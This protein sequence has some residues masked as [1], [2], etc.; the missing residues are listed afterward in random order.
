MKESH[1]TRHH[2]SAKLVYRGIASPLSLIFCRSARNSSGVVGAVL[3][4]ASLHTRLLYATPFA[5]PPLQM[6]YTVPSNDLSG[7]K[8]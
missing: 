7:M 2:E 1:W 8:L 5:L 6:P 3:M 4:P